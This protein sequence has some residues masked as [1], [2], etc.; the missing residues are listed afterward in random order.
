[1]EQLR[2]ADAAALSTAMVDEHGMSEV[3][4]RRLLRAISIAQAAAPSCTSSWHRHQAG[5]LRTH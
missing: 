5:T 3:E 4:R 2:V 1:M